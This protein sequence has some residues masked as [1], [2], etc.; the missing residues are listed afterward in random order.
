MAPIL[1]VNGLRKEFKGFALKNISF[2]KMT[3]QQLYRTI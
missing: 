3:E 1:E 2:T